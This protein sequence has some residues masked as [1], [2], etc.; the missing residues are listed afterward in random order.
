MNEKH[1][2][3][4]KRE[5]ILLAVIAIFAAIISLFYRSWF[6]KPAAVVEIA[7][8]DE[9]S[10]RTILNTFDLYEN[11][12]YRIQTGT[13]TSES[14]ED[15]NH[16]IIQNG[17]AWISEANCP[18]RDCVKKGKIQENGEMLVCIPHRLTVTILAK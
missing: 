10:N 2:L 8:V 14:T 13:L 3:I 5:I 12:E 4:G 16:L 9:Q 15:F 18:N 17:T 6:S 11:T 1:K 7:I